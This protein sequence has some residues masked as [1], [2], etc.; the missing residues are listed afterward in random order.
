MDECLVTCS[1]GCRMSS[2]LCHVDSK[3][4]V[5]SR[6]TRV[7]NSSCGV[8]ERRPLMLVTRNLGLLA[9]L[10]HAVCG[11]YRKSFINPGDFILRRDR[12]LGE[13]ALPTVA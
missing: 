6:S 11:I 7:L 2:K 13:P 8:M 4:A 10:C 3:Q 12:H 1:S 5:V 9:G